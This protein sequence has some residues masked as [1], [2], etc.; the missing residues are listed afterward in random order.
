MTY[1]QFEHILANVT[2]AMP[3]V[4][5]GAHT[6]KSIAAKLHERSK[7]TASKADDKVTQPILVFATWLDLIATAVAH[8]ASMGFFMR[9]DDTD[10]Q[11]QD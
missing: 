5:G 7:A 3:F 2:L 11:A 8:A 10:G 9:K 1:Q 6:F 4:L